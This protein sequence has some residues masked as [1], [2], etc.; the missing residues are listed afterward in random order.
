MK[1]PTERIE[2]VSVL[3]TEPTVRLM[4]FT[5]PAEGGS[6]E[7][8]IERAAR[9]CYQ[10]QAHMSPE[11]G[12]RFI[13]GIILRGHE[14]V[15]EHASATFRVLGGSRAYTHEQVRHRLLSFSQQSQRYVSEKDFRA[16][17]PPA[18]AD[19]PE[20]RKVFVELLEE[21]RKAY[22]RLKELGLGNEDARFVL[23]N[24]VESGIVISG[25]FREWRHV[26][27]TR[28]S[29]AAQWEIRR[30]C[31]LMLKLAR[32][33]APVVFGDLILDE[34][35]WIVTHISE[36]VDC[37]KAQKAIAHE[38]AELGE[39]GQPPSRILRLLADD[40]LYAA[41]FHVKRCLCEGCKAA[42]AACGDLK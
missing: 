25:N 15:L 30:I 36:T 6:V 10:S 35:T 5:R 20:A 40:G 26:F 16:V 17:L 2:A 1:T 23:P 7:E 29:A 34:E 32:E 18:I 22:R 13:R 39:E 9:E 3:L 38:L 8:H 4:G 37:T 27:R 41:L 28:C 24:A 14:S 11:S 42:F 19:N 12:K 33:I 31:G 21:T